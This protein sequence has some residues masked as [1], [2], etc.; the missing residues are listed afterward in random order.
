[1]VSSE[2]EALI[3]RYIAAYKDKFHL[4]PQGTCDNCGEM[5]NSQRLKDILR[6]TGMAPRGARP[7]LCI[8]CA[9]HYGLV[10]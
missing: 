8:D 10:W 2:H 9:R 6:W 1:M 7:F 5:N 3:R 4:D